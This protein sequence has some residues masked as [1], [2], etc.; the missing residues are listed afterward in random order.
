MTWEDMFGTSPL[1][2]KE[3]YMFATIDR[4]KRAAEKQ[5][6]LREVD[7]VF[8]YKIEGKFDIVW[9]SKDWEDQVPE[10]GIV[11]LHGIKTLVPSPDGAGTKLT[12][13]DR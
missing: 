2:E 13:E 9:D 10:G 11:V 4:A 12:W 6:K 7:H 5:V 8:V 1:D 3:R